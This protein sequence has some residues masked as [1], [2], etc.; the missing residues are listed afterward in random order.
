VKHLVKLFND[1]GE[2]L[3][4]KHSTFPAGEVYV[5]IVDTSKMT[6]RMTIGLY[7]ASSDS[8]MRV[9]MLASAT[10]A[11][12]LILEATYMPYS[13]QDRVCSEGE[14]D[15]FF[16]F[17]LI[18]DRFFDEIITVDLHN[19]LVAR[20]STTSLKPDYSKLLSVRNQ[21]TI[22]TVVD[23]HSLVVAPD[24]GALK[25][26]SDFAL[27][28]D[29]EV[30]SMSKTRTAIGVEQSVD[31]PEVMAN[32]TNIIIVDDICDGGAT[33]LAATMEIRK[34]NKQANLYLIISHGIFSAGTARLLEMFEDVFVLNNQYN[35]N[36]L[37]NLLM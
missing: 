26:A 1:L 28:F 12:Y 21:E 34:Y 14:A 25:R 6:N 20:S 7:D 4:V 32:A 18:L 31:E 15:S 29:C 2:E 37:C 3:E 9:I 27:E 24:K 33:F 22:N 17:Q 19:P 10:T 23:S 5:K 8:I 35:K 30:T 36:R 13:R 16:E 11:N